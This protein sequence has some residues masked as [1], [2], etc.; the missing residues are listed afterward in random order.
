MAKKSENLS[1]RGLY[2]KNLAASFPINLVSLLLIVQG[3]NKAA[4]FQVLSV[5]SF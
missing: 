1:G 3:A 5:L 2:K 4:L